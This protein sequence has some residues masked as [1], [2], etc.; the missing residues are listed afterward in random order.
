MIVYAGL[1][2]VGLD[3][4]ICHLGGVDVRDQDQGLPTDCRA[5]GGWRF[6]GRWAAAEGRM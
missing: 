2:L 6:S 4:G 3:W 5:V 1:R